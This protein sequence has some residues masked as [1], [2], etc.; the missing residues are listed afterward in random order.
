MD[1]FKHWF[2]CLTVC[3]A[4]FNSVLGWLLLKT[5]KPRHVGSAEY[6]CLKVF[7]T[8]VPDCH[9][10]ILCSHI[11]ISV[12]TMCYSFSVCGSKN[13]INKACWNVKFCWVCC[14]IKT[15]FWKFVSF[16][17]LLISDFFC[18]YP[19]SIVWWCGGLFELWPK[20]LGFGLGFNSQWDQLYFLVL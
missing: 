4:S 17:W 13:Q 19:E 12:I 9:W 18:C 20:S 3:C 2:Q 5:D 14:S 11:C 10:N 1:W 7:Q 8:S 15:V 6:R 16:N